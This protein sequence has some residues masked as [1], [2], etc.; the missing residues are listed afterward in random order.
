LIRAS[1]ETDEIVMA[2]VIA[3]AL[4]ARK[5]RPQ[6]A[7]ARGYWGNVWQRLRYDYVTLFC[8]ALI[9]AIVLLAIFAPLVAP[10]DPYKSSMAHRLRPIGA[11]GHLLGTDEQGRDMLSRL[12]FG[13]RVSLTMGILPVALATVIGG[14]LGVVAGYFAGGVN[15]AI[16]RTMDVFFAFPSVLLAVAISGSLGGGI[17]NQLITLTVILIPPLCRV[18]ETATSQVRSMDFVDAARS[19]DASTASILLTHV[20]INILSPVL[21]YASTLVSV[22][23]IL[24]SG[25]SFLGLGVSPPTPDWG[26]MLSTL[27]ESIYVQ[28]L[29]S[30]VPGIAILITS[31][32]FNL[33]SDGLRQAMDVRA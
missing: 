7:K 18:A 5:E 31:I 19:T 20:L 4:P 8:L 3:A 24:A 2:H 32:T 6:V 27:R 14:L 17:S 15:M 33:V 11:P 26:L 12:I 9:I 21:V 22:S 10:M 16:M 28:P 29:V 1:S 23:I 30:A 13:G 25:L